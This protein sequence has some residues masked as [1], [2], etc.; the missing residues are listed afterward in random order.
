M[1]LL[2]VHSPSD[3]YGASRSLLRLV[4][5]LLNDGNSVLVVLSQDGP[6]REQ[7]LATGAQIH[8]CPRLAVIDRRKYRSAVRLLALIG[9][10][11][12]SCHELSRICK[13]Y[14]PDLIH[15]NTSLI[16]TSGLVASA[17]QIPHVWHIREIFVDFP[18]MW[19]W[20]QWVMVLLSTRIICVSGAVAAQFSR[21]V[22]RNKLI[23]LHNGFP[24]AEF[25]GIGIDRAREFR[26]RYQLNGHLLV[27]MVGR[28]KLGRKGQEILLQAA[29]RLA[30]G[31]S[32]VKF[33]FIGSPFPGNEDQLTKF[34][35]MVDALHLRQHVVY[36]GDA[37]DIKGAYAALDISVQASTMPEAFS[38]VVIESMAMG[39]AIIASDCGAV[40]E[41]ID[42]G[43]TG[44]IVRPNDPA[45]L[46]SGLK[47]LIDDEPMR[48]R[49]GA[50]AQHKFLKCFEFDQFY[51]SLLN[52]YS[53]LLFSGTT[54]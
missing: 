44:I 21:R 54:Q 20:Y 42:D 2:F 39:K 53:N 15:T 5:R 3:L 11:I 18:R 16:L 27:G 17:R 6:L 13:T 24:A 46:A 50:N 48:R 41:Q 7:L 26:N 22:S 25:S 4:T 28:I 33:A 29:S 19:S 37:E 52:L 47:Q 40:T 30:S 32:N 1:K 34:N 12:S 45:Q 35:Q 51:R 23:V 31:A 10:L 38:G 8:L 14:K 9:S 43:V 49:L 36:T